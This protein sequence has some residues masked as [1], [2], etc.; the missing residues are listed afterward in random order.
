VVRAPRLVCGAIPI[1]TLDGGVPQIGLR[2]SRDAARCASGSSTSGAACRSRR[3][4]TVIRRRDT[5]LACRARATR[6]S[7]SGRCAR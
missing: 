3:A 5:F 7:G 4:A 1:M 2:G 6:T